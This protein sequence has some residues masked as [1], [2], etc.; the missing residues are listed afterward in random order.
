MRA[1]YMLISN[2]TPP[3]ERDTIIQNLLLYCGQDTL[4]MVRIFEALKKM[5]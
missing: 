5:C 3:D 2:T 1:L 4:A